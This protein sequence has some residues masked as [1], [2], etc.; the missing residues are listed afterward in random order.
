MRA[1]LF[2]N[3]PLPIFLLGGTGKLEGGT[4]PRTAAALPCESGWDRQSS[5]RRGGGE[6]GM[7]W[8]VWRRVRSDAPYRRGRARPFADLGC[9]LK[10]SRGAAGEG[11][12]RREPW[13]G[14]EKGTSPGGAEESRRW[15]YGGFCRPSEAWRGGRFTHGW[16]RE[17]PSCAP[18]ALIG[19]GCA[20]SYAPARQVISAWENGPNAEDCVPAF[21]K[22]IGQ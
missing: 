16:R 13:V 12:P 14:R 5:A 18:P 6:W 22:R 21:T 19:N 17:L 11:S 15:K 10:F 4:R 9:V 7:R 20:S 3:L 1:A 8:V 2:P